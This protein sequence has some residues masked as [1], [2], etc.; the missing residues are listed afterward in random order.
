[1]DPSL[2]PTGGRTQ[3]QSISVAPYENPC[4]H[5]EPVVPS[6]DRAWNANRTRPRCCPRHR[7]QSKAPSY[8]CRSRK[9]PD[10]T[11]VA[12]AREFKSPS[13]AKPIPPKAAPSL[14]QSTPSFKAVSGIKHQAWHPRAGL[15]LRN[16]RR[17]DLTKAAEKSSVELH[18]LIRDITTRES[19]GRSSMPSHRPPSRAPPSLGSPLSE[20]APPGT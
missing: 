2:H 14:S 13:T 17:V 3:N 15:K 20:S 12:A 9:P 11:G 19:S 5:A 10:P 4:W 7:A 6:W 18:L 16:Q 1:V 8:P